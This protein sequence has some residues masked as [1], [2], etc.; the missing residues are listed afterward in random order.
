M[1]KKLLNNI[2]LKLIS[3]L[4]AM[5][6]WLVITNI[7]DATTTETITLPIQEINAEDLENLFMFYE[8][9]DLFRRIWNLKKDYKTAYFGTKSIIHLIGGTREED[10]YAGFN[11]IRMNLDS[12]KYYA[13]KYHLNF[14]SMIRKFLFT[15]YL[16][17]IKAYMIG[18]EKQ[19][20]EFK[21][22][23]KYIKDI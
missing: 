23:I 16:R 7:D 19:V 18:N 4:V 11:S 10:V 22:I 15:I 9:S 14:E 3:V 8:E 13:K 17:M 21:K 6:I 2:G 12:M 20:E 5:L 1:K